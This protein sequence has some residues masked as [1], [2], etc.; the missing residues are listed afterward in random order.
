MKKTVIFLLFMLPLSTF[1]LSMDEHFASPRQTMD[2]FLTHMAQYK[3]GNRQAL[4]IAIHALN[5]QDIDQN[6]RRHIARR[7]AID[8]INTL[9][10]IEKIDIQKIPGSEFQE[11]LWRYR[12][13]NISLFGQRQTVEIA[14]GKTIL[15]DEQ[16]E[17]DQQ[18]WLFTPS[19]V[20]SIGNYYLYLQNRPVV[21]GVTELRTWQQTMRRLL[22][23]WFFRETFVLSN[24]QWF[25]LF[26]ILLI[27]LILE[28]VVKVYL[29]FFTQRFTKKF[30][31]HFQAQKQRKVNIAL[32][33][34]TLSL[35]WNAGVLFLD[36]NQA[37]L[38]IMLK[39]GRIVFTLGVVS[40]LYYAVEVITFY[41]EEKA[42]QTRNRFDE[43]LVP[44]ARKAAKTVIISLGILAVG[45]A[46]GLD[47][48]GL[49]AG[50]GIGGIAFALAARDTISNMFGSLTVILDRPFE[51][52]DWVNI[53]GNVEGIVEQVG[54][55][56]TRVR[57]FYDS[58]ISVPNGTLTNIHIDNY[59]RRTYRRYMNRLSLQYDT[60][61]EKIEAY[62]EGLRQLILNHPMTRKDLFHVY[63]NDYNN[64]S[65]DILVYLFWKVP[66]WSSELAE[67][68]RFL[69]DSLRLARELDI[70]FA[71]PT[72]TL[73]MFKEEH[74]DYQK[75]FEELPEKSYQ[76]AKSKALKILD[77]PLTLLGPRSHQN[78]FD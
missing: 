1:G 9:D 33:L 74:K 25:G 77:R 32:T 38:S 13:E 45:D 76:A 31:L 54:L 41:L 51:I 10:R 30:N 70:R 62:C 58:L 28:K 75:D 20:Q 34:V 67:R 29:R 14:I 50:L 69:I 52:G 6:T 65:L 71:F 8:L 23:A 11:Q 39:L 48:K 17:Q 72:R 27:G 7:A 21:E 18:V 19:T 55:R 16:T 66:D 35:V 68:H 36:F 53:G 22:P 60:P 49:I 2:F 73:H 47:M 61:I 37:A 63:F 78:N 59:G 46:L 3:E 42:R 5:T 40:A 15:Q 12:R 44:L 43:I 4:D 57:T 64:S 56:S 24:L 26:F